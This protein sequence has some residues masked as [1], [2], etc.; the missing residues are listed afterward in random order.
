[1]SS[2]NAAW[3]SESRVVSEYQGEVGQGWPAV[4][5]GPAGL[6]ERVQPQRDE[7]ETGYHDD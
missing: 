7:C 2:G 5:P 6:G 3:I 1:M 4:H